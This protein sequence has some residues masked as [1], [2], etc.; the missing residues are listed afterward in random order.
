MNSLPIVAPEELEELLGRPGPVLVDFWQ[1][2]CAPC[3]ALEPRLAAALARA[4]GHVQAVRIDL[5]A[6]LHL[7]KRFDVMSLP[8]VLVFRSGAETARLDGLIRE[9]DVLHAL[10]GGFGGPER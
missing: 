2:S 9:E 5:D 6:H 1:E 10:H 8:T 3:R 4:E 7:A